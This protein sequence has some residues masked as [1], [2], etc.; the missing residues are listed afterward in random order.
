MIPNQRLFNEYNSLT[1]SNLTAY[2]SNRYLRRHLRKIGLINKRG[3]IIPESTYRANISR[4]EQREQVKE[5]LAQAI[6]HK[7][8]DLQLKRENEINRKVEEISKLELVR[9]M[10]SERYTARSHTLLTSA[11]SRESLSRRASSVAG[12]MRHQPWTNSRP[13]TAYEPQGTQNSDMSFSSLDLESKCSTISRDH[14]TLQTQN[15]STERDRYFPFYLDV[16]NLRQYGLK[17][18]PLHDTWNKQLKSPYLATDPSAGDRMKPVRPK[19][20]PKLMSDHNGSKAERYNAEA[21][22]RTNCNV[23]MKF[24]GKHVTKLPSDSVRET[25]VVVQQQHCGGNTVCVY[26]GKLL[27]QENFTFI[28]HRHINFPFSLSVYLDGILHLR[29]S[30]CCEYR[31]H[32]G[33]IIGGPQGQ[34]ILVSVKGSMPCARCKLN[35]D[36]RQKKQ[37]KTSHGKPPESAFHQIDH[38]DSMLD[39]PD[40]RS[41]RKKQ[42]K[43]QSKEMPSSQEEHEDE[44]KYDH[45]SRNTI[46]WDDDTASVT[47]DVADSD[48]EVQK[49]ENQEAGYE[50]D[51]DNDADNEEE[52]EE[53]AEETDD[54]DNE[55]DECEEIEEEKNEDES[56]VADNESII[57]EVEKESTSNSDVPLALDTTFDDGES[58]TDFQKADTE[59]VDGTE[60]RET[61]LAKEGDRNASEAINDDQQK[62]HV[63]QP[64]TDQGDEIVEEDISPPRGLATG[65][66]VTATSSTLPAAVTSTGTTTPTSST[67]FAGATDMA[68]VTSE[69][70]KEVHKDREEPET[71][72]GAPVVIGEQAADKNKDADGDGVQGHQSI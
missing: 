46:P 27:P 31:H 47:I 6:V 50:D 71:N 64:S 45:H 32:R 60:V 4:A 69:D 28:S 30:V 43:F 68:K 34:F 48:D 40:G 20:T 37:K 52:K 12:S 58:R 2:F 7:S 66:T 70:R 17:L 24:L 42:T 22:M 54:Y 67:I 35:K 11:T 63:T 57:D 51:F 25:E 55:E 13:R 29:V 9:K 18:A 62:N 49:E 41:L 53:E 23:T 21:R 14:S 56:S 65:T 15:S 26:H 39:E 16:N 19:T 38:R 36:L 1:D 8:V 59:N 72:K 3:E 10:R 44:Q 33:G 5:A 61:L